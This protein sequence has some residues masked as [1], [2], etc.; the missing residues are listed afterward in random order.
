MEKLRQMMLSGGGGV[1][2]GVSTSEMES[3]K[4]KLQISEGLMA[5]MTKSWEEKLKET[6]RLHRVSWSIVYY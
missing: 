6:E 2:G 1:G 4:E 5:E 3:L